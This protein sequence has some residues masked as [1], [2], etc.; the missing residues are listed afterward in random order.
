MLSEA[1]LINHQANNQSAKGVKAKTKKVNH[2]AKSVKSQTNSVSKKTKSESP[3]PLSNHAFTS[4]NTNTLTHSTALAVDV[5]E[6]EPE[7]SCSQVEENI[8][9]YLTGSTPPHNPE[10]YAEWIYYTEHGKLPETPE[11]RKAKFNFFN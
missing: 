3:K 8:P 2:Q 6:E 1:K 7:K 9:S 10:Q 5:S 4:S 11:Q